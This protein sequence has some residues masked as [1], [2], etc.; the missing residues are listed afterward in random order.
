MCLLL[1]LFR[2]AIVRVAIIVR[3]LLLL[4]FTC[5]SEEKQSPDVTRKPLVHS[6][7]QKHL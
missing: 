3:L 6:L 1:I 4:L 2:I 7:D 5:S